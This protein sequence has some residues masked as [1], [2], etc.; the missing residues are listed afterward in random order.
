MTKIKMSHKEPENNEMKCNQDKNGGFGPNYIYLNKEDLITFFEIK[1]NTLSLASKIAK[2]IKVKIPF[3]I[4]ENVAKLSAMLLDG[5]L[6]RNLSNLMFCQKKDKNKVKEFKNIVRRLFGLKSKDRIFNNDSPGVVANSKALGVFLHKC[7]GLHKSN[8]PARIPSWIL[9]SPP[10][11]TL[12]YLRYAFAMEGSVS[13]YIKGPEIK[14]HSVDLPYLEDL[15]SLLKNKFDINSIIQ[16]YYI[17][18]YG[19]KYYLSITNQREIVKFQEIG[20]ALKSHQTKLEKLTSH[21]KD[22][23][24]EITLVGVLRLNKRTVLVSDLKETF[25]YLLRDAIR[26]RLDLLARKGYLQ[27]EEQVYSLTEEGYKVAS[28]LENKIKITRLRTDPRENEERIV[29]F[30]DFKGSS[31]RNEIARELK[32]DSSTIHD[33]LIRLINNKKVKFIGTDKFQR[34]FYEVR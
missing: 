25:P 5:S 18:N 11:V 15:R 7:L 16:K 3:K 24:W 17:D 8:E 20:F 19:W 14:F 26:F 10:S 12:A 22:K 29:K 23:A 34:K 6:N 31:Y 13:S 4:D 1:G 28:F 32:I 21:F 9:K 27:K 33:A 2:P 30:I